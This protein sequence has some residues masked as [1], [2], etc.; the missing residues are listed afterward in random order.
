[1]R[2][3]PYL[4]SALGAALTAGAAETAAPQRII[5]IRTDDISLILSAAPGEEVRFLH[6]GGRIDDP[7]PLAG[8]RSYRHP[9]HNTED[10][11]YPAFGGRNYHE[12][13][14][15][16]THADGDL[17]TELRYVSHRTRKLAD[18]NVTET[19]V[20]MT[21]AVQPLDVELVYTAYARENVITTRAV[22]RN[23]EKGP[24]TLHSFYSS[25]MPLR[26][27]KY[28]L[29]HLHGAWTREAQVEHTLLTHGSKSIASTRGLRTTHAENPSF[30][31]TLGNDRFDENCGEVVAGS[32]A[33]SGN[34]RLNFELD[35][36]QTLTVLAGANPDASEYRLR[37]GESFTTP[38]MIYTHSFRGAGGAS[39]NLHDWARNYGVW[40]GHIPAPT[41][42]NSWEGAAFS[43]DAKTLTDMIDD[44][45]AMGLEMFVLDDGWFGN[46]Y[47][48]NNDKAGLGD[49]EVNREKLPEGIDHIASYAHDKGL[50]FGIW[51]E[52]EMV[53]P[54]SEL[55][56]KHPEW[57]VR[58]PGREAPLTRSQW[59]LDLSNP[60]VQDFVFG[61]F[62]NT[63]R[64]SEHIDYI[65]WD[66]NRCANSIGSAFQRPDEQSH[67]WIEYTQ[68]LY[69]VMER[70]RAKYPDVLIQSCASGG[71]RVEYGALRYFD[72]VW[73]SDNTEAL[74]RTRIQYGTSLFFPALVMGSHVSVTPNL[75]T[76]NST[77]LKFR[78]DIACAGRLGM[79][80]QP[81]HMTE[82][83]RAEAR[84]AIADYKEYRDIVM[85]G[86]LYRIGSPYDEDG[87][88]G[89]AYV[90][91]DKRRAV[92][93][94]YCLL[95]QS[96]TVPQFRIRGLDPDTRY[97]V[98]E[99]NTEEPRFWF[100]GGTF[101]GELLSRM[102]LN[103][104]L[105][106]IYDS[107]VFLLEAR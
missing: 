68:G 35:E 62:D 92:V 75:Q 71:G 49:W 11:A 64:L 43:F 3:L 22:I 102:G 107:A 105:S 79:E 8:Y 63:M 100:D 56:E 96:R 73:T 59:L 12:P 32:L 25:A 101:S 99:M 42:L 70:I 46:K 13:A 98:R 97:T 20:R 39:R 88:Y 82:E 50:K 89:L 36:C 44:A 55:A 14:L 17:N 41:L 54:R 6:F 93:F 58:T 95:Y 65:K 90:S 31:L 52:P 45:A 30:M 84:R 1:M 103:P 2:K 15:R 78:F 80:L 33:W 77:P 27:E 9:D 4:L 91:K 72:E 85:Q 53:S 104:K 21:D 106:R 29:T 26:A 48:R 10:V 66:A 57:I 86:D 87:C 94:T 34:F 69:K 37:P 51:I 74:S 81:K 18:D 61:V 23:R 7:A 76:G 47:P 40:H 24:V 28:L 5:D 67:F 83:E 38:E 16:V 19:V 60:E